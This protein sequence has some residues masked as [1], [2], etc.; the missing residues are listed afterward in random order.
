MGQLACKDRRCLD[1]QS[2]AHVQL[3]DAIRV[4]VTIDERRER[5]EVIRIQAL[6]TGRIGQDLLEHERVDVDQG[7]LQQV[8]AQDGPV[9]TK[10]P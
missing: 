4:A 2:L 3:E 1:R 10:S 6:E 8:Q 7:D 5:A 9:S